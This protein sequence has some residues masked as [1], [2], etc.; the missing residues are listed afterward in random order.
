MFVGNFVTISIENS[1]Y[2][3]IKFYVQ[4]VQNFDVFF[5]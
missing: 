1:N 5:V 4:F 3:L 2:A